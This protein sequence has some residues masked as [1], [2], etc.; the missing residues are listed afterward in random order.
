VFDSDPAVHEYLGNLLQRPGRSIQDAY[1]RKEAFDYLRHTPCDLILAGQGPNG[2]ME[3]I[4]LLRRVRS[5]QPQ[6]RVIL[7]GE[8]DPA[9]VV[10]AI[11]EHAFSYIH[12]PMAEGPVADMVQQAL[13]ARTWRDDIRV[14]SAR[15]EWITLEVRSKLDTADR[16]THFFREM[17]ADL[18]AGFRE[19][20]AAAFREL[21]MNGIEHGARSDP[22]KRVRAA[23]LRTARAVMVHVSDPGKGFNFNLLPHAAISNPAHSPI[24]HVEIRAEQGQRPGGF[25]ILLTRNL[26]DELLY[27]ERGNA[28][29][30]VKYFQNDSGTKPAG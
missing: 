5:L 15:P 28:A 2:G 27:N 20:V 10:R 21:L 16:T 11:R 26:A 12:T 18:P 8:P 9:R 23:L 25:G 3:G 4:R 7:T 17:L 6:A 13:D 22:S 19:D 24:R 30:F 29:L 14:V 1:N